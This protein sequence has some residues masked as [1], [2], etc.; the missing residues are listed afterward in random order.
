M[1]SEDNFRVSLVSPEGEAV[2]ESEPATVVI[3]IKENLM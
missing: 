2:A 3:A 1:P